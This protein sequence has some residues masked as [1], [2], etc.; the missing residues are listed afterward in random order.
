L[1]ASFQHLERL[2]LDGIWFD[3][4]EVAHPSPEKR[5]FKGTFYLVDWYDSSEEFVCLLAEHDLRFRE[6]FVNG[7]CWLHDTTWNRCLTKCADHLEKFGIH[8]SESDGESACC[9]SN[10]IALFI[11]FQ[12]FPTDRFKTPTF[13]NL[14]CLL[15]QASSESTTILPPPELLSSITSTNLSE[16]II[17]IT[18]FPPGEELDA[19]IN[20]IREFDGPLCRLA[21]QLD[22]SS[23]SEKLVLTLGV[24]EELPD[25][26]AVLPRFS[27]SGVFKM[28]VTGI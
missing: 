8:W 17:D 4:S 25:L 2:E 6:M 23:G 13:Q 26:A 12:V 16:I 27:K 28:V 9:R 14:R 21:K 18:V 7:E 20:A 19:A 10:W 24:V 5:T 11:L 1:A 15:V 22:P 3:P